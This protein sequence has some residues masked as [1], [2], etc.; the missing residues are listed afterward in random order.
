M[1]FKELPKLPNTLEVLYCTE[2]ELTELPDLPYTMK[3]LVCHDT[4][5]PYDDIE[6]YWE[7]CGENNK[8][9]ENYE[10]YLINKIMKD[11]NI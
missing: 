10:K 3:K 8:N 5:L 1:N 9:Q 11:F 4:D 2:N 7:W 6:S